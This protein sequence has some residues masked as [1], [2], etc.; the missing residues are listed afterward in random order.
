MKTVLDPTD[1][2]NYSTDALVTAASMIRAMGDSIVCMNNVETLLTNWTQRSASE[3]MKHPE[4][5]NH[6]DK[7]FREI[8]EI[9]SGVLLSGISVDSL[10]T[11]GVTSDEI[12]AAA[13]QTKADLIVMG[14][15]E[16]KAGRDFIGSTLQRVV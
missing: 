1:F 2:S 5:R 4:L 7:V 11:Y 15:G 10:I 12:V 13:I 14:S 8:Q 3:R 6:T 9:K 16:P